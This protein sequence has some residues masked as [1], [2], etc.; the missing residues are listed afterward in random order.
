MNRDNLN[1]R[2]WMRARHPD[3]FSDTLIDDAPRLPKAVFEYHLETLTSRKQEYEFEHFCRKLAEKEICP[4]LRVQTGPTG[5]GDSKVD[6]ETYPVAEEIAER[7][8]IGS[9]SAGAERWAFAFSAKEKWKP[10]IKADVDKIISTGRDYKQIYFFTNQFVSDKE[11][12]VQEDLLSKHTR[13]PVHIIDRTWMVERVYKSGHLELAIA[14]LSIEDV[15]REKASR[16][17]PLDVARLRELE[18]L[19]LQVLDPLRYRGARYQLAEDCLR[20]AILARGLERPRNEVEGRFVQADRLAEK[21]DYRQQRLRIAYNRAWT[22][23]WWYED[24]HLFSHFYE[25]VEQRVEGSDQVDDVEFLLNLWHLLAPSV[26]AGRLSAQDA[27]IEPRQ[28]RL[29]AMLEVIAADPV[30]PNNALQAR[31]G[32]TLMRITQAYQTEQSDQLESGWRELSQIVE[33]S[34]DLGS[35]PLERLSNIV[36]E[37]GEKVDSPAF[38]MLY[39]RVVGVVRLR[40][41]D[42]EAGEAYTE[43]GI[44]KL[45]Q[46]KPYEAIQWLGRA[47]KLLSKEEYLTELVVALIA[48][49]CAYERVGL[50]WAARNK[51]LAAV[52]RTLAVFHSQGE[53]IQPALLALQRLVWIELQL[54]RIPHV[55][56]AM[57]L[58][59]L[60]ASHLKLTEDRQKAYSEERQVQEAVLGIHFLN[61]P[62]EALSGLSRLPG[63]LE[64]QGLIIARMALL[65]SLGQ[66]QALRK[67]GH[68]PASEDPK[69]VQTFFELWQDQPAAKDIPPQPMLMDGATSLLTSTVLGSEL[70][71]ETPNNA[72]SFSVVES[73]LGAL[74][75]FMATSD[76]QDVLPHRERMT[77]VVNASDQLAGAP[78]LRFTD[79]NDHAEIVHPIDL[80]F[81]TA[82]ERQEYL[83]WL[84]ESLLQIIS[85]LLVPW[86]AREWLEKIAGQELGFSRALV[87]GDVLTLNNNIFGSMPRL[88]LS[89]WSESEGEIWALLRNGPWR[90]EKTVEP[91]RTI[92]ADEL[93]NLG[94][95]PAPRDLINR[96]QLKHSDRRILSPID[97]PL[98]DQAKWRATL[99]A[100]PPYAP[101]MLALVFESGQDG[102]KIFRSWRERWGGE[103]KDEVLRLAIV[104]GL[105]KRNPAEYAVL[106][107]S[108]PSY[109]KE[110]S[111]KVFVF[112]S[113]IHRMT[114]AST[115]NLDKFIAAYQR[116]GS[117][118]FAPAQ[119]LTSAPV[120]FA[121]LAIVKRQL[122]IRQA[123]QIGEN[124]PDASVLQHDDEPIIP[125]EVV[126]P[127]V[128]S[129]LRRIRSSRHRRSKD[130]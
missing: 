43:R 94:A 96:A 126:D 13:I 55:L 81:K 114:P 122:H 120:P 72:I 127:P 66:E 48:S 113:R 70:V 23:Y 60:I 2:E 91:A 84:Q 107:G 56:S 10:K 57:T 5:G 104:T 24:Y 69:A 4:N 32:L 58:A 27:K 50:L 65:F 119:F 12:S 38:D 78:L 116:A 89:D 54:G 15:R 28:R 53:V 61:I 21:L 67:E 92:G 26:A 39:E 25:E 108:N 9:L 22:A 35:Y 118:L 123:W 86:N 42:G 115:I 100:W 37:L 7:W 105:S 62:F 82:D 130:V 63:V 6:T 19:D 17:G 109:A 1:P 95:G 34:A 125:P 77:I 73:L 49:S 51:A 110:S 101:P 98:W 93:S 124:D 112:V 68:I 117:F 8:W 90:V 29:T 99:F 103:D 44:Q 74:E 83:Q 20:G 76:E 80:E 30:R 128:V 106:V 71:V 36:V 87:F 111:E 102:Q 45:Q 3:F 18:E 75:A 16:T 40:R 47:E 46:R 97:V 121:E 41:S 129:A 79:S 33:E 88:R 64:R 59:S 14:T 85:R 52:E 31:T 11:R